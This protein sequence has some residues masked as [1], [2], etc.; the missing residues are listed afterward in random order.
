MQK[1][2]CCSFAMCSP[3]AGACERSENPGGLVC[4]RFSERRRLKQ[5]ILTWIPPRRKMKSN[6]S[7]V[8]KARSEGRMPRVKTNWKEGKWHEQH[9]LC[10]VTHSL[11]EHR[12]QRAPDHVSGRLR[13]RL[14]RVR[15]TLRSSTRAFEH[16]TWVLANLPLSALAI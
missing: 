11:R 2:P 14:Q 15:G 3:W 7:G 5:Q 1:A 13:P 9:R 8:R 12:L 4:Q 6:A 16:T 10:C